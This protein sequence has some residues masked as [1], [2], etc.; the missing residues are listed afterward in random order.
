MDIAIGEKRKPIS[1]GIWLVLIQAHLYG[2]ICSY[3]TGRSYGQASTTDAR[4]FLT[5]EKYVEPLRELN[6]WL[7]GCEHRQASTA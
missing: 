2:V 3:Y 6:Y 1:C 5:S 4:H 7:I